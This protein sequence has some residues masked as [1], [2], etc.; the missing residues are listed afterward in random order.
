MVMT[1]NNESTWHAVSPT[2]TFNGT[3]YMMSWDIDPVRIGGSWRLTYMVSANLTGSTHPVGLGSIGVFT[4]FEN[5]SAIYNRDIL[6]DAIYIGDSGNLS[7]TDMLN[8]SITLPT[9]GYNIAQPYQ[10]IAWNVTYN[11]TG[12]Y[13]QLLEF[14]PEGTNNYRPIASGFGSDQSGSFE[15]VWDIAKTGV[16]KGRYTIRIT[17][18]DGMFIASATRGVVVSYMSGEINLGEPSVKLPY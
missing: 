10:V 16:G 1:D 6:S 12:A 17:A 2:I 11:A 5:A 3:H 14:A 13:S 7:A 9:E 4:P 8:V 18:T 15:T